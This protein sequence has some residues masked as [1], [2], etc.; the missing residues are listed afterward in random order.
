[1]R[2]LIVIGI[3]AGCGSAPPRDPERPTESECRTAAERYVILAQDQLGGPFDRALMVTVEQECEEIWT[4]EE[5]GCVRLA[6]TLQAA[7][8]CLE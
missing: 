4:R 1:M 2:A 8:A 5:Y 6:L 7:N 3:L